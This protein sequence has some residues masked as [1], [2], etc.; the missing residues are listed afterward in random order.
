MQ[1]RVS[2]G[3]VPLIKVDLSHPEDQKQLSP[4]GAGLMELNIL[5][6][7]VL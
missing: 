4:V 6:F 3:M 5:I 1:N 2:L 7:N